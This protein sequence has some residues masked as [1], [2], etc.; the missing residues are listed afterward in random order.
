[1]AFQDKH[2]KALSVVQFFSLQSGLLERKLI[3][4]FFR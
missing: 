4:A 2:L 1:M 3:K